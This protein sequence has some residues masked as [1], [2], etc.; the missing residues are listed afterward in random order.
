M[1]A[2]FVTATKARKWIPIQ[3]STMPRLAVLDAIKTNMVSDLLA[4]TATSHM[5][6]VSHML[7][8]WYATPRIVQKTFYPILEK[9]RILFVQL[10]MAK[11]TINF[12]LIRPN[13]QPC[14][15][16]P[17]MSPTAK[18]QGVS[19][20]IKN[21]MVLQYTNGSPTVWNAMST[22]MTSL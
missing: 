18:F 21:H 1:L 8:A 16:Q 6:P 11:S 13:I 15:V 19:N 4:L 3:T 17:A 20:V 7:T 22:H 9:C 2:Q 12:R 14:N 5:L 10:A